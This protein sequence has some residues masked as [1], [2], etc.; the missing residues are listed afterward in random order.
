[1][2][3]NETNE[4][5]EQLPVGSEAVGYVAGCDTCQFLDEYFGDCCHPDGGGS[6]DYQ[7]SL[8]ICLNNNYHWW[9]LKRSLRKA[10]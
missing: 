9:Q 8:D 3:S 7:P 6:I 5:D 2:E 10:T 1:M 4:S